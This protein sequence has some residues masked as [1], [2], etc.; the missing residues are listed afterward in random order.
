MAACGN[1]TRETPKGHK[2]VVVTKG[3][4][5]VANPGEYILMDIVIKDSNDSVW[6]D[7]RN[8]DV[9][10]ILSIQGEEV[11]ETEEGIEEIFRLLS[12]GDSVI[13]TMTAKDFFE[14]TWRQPMPPTMDSSTEFTFYMKLNEILDQAGLQAVEEGMVAKQLQKDIEIIDAHLEEIGIEAQ[15]TPSGLRYFI[16]EEGSGPNAAIGQEVQIHYAGYLLDGTLFDS[17]MESIARENGSYTE[18]RPYTPLALNAGE[19]Q[20]IAG[21]EEAMLLMNKGAKMKVWIPSTL[22]YG[23]RSRSALI[24]ENS[25]LMFDMEMVDVK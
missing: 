25:I 17:S 20:V 16:T 18:G 22:A 8:Q 21:W 9:P 23:P 19:G 11:K 5:V 3:D 2:Y 12:K 10:L 13:F 15:S 24:K 1:E 7:S 6:N 14:K 4:G